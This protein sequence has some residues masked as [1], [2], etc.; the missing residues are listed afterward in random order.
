VTGIRRLIKVKLP[1]VIIG[2]ARASPIGWP[3]AAK[4]ESALSPRKNC[5]FNS[6]VLQ[7]TAAHCG[8]QHPTEWDVVGRF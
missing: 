8:I 2:E 6:G 3:F 7:R 1:N 5:V 4:T